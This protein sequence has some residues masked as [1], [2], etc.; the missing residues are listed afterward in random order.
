M[1]TLSH[2]LPR[3]LDGVHAWGISTHRQRVPARL[4]AFIGLA[5]ERY[6]ALRETMRRVCVALEAR[7]STEEYTLP[8]FPAFR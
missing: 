6:P 1:I 7:W 4:E 5:D 8:T 3:A 2:V